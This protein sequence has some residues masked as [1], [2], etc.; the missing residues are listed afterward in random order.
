MLSRFFNIFDSNAHTSLVL[1]LHYLIVLPYNLD[2]A[3]KFPQSELEFMLPHLELLV[4]KL[5]L[6]GILGELCLGPLDLELITDGLHMLT[7]L[8]EHL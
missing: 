7:I 3:F 4:L 2:V 8:E 5:D 1:L 6:L